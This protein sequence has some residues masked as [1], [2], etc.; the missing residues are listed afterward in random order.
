VL[1]QSERPDPRG[2][3]RRGQGPQEQEGEGSRGQRAVTTISPRSS[4]SHAS[5]PIN[6]P[7]RISKGINTIQS[8]GK[9]EHEELLSNRLWHNTNTS[10]SE[11]MAVP[12]PVA[13]LAAVAAAAAAQTDS[14][15]RT[16][17]PDP[18]ER[19]AGCSRGRRF[20][21]EYLQRGRG[22]M[23]AISAS[24]LDRCKLSVRD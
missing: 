5:K 21:P 20:P 6:S 22:N 1:R 16:H 24:V 15:S 11:R 19:P 9:Q 12:H 23:K 8:W 4:L 7:S 10:R 3:G 17:L 13:A 2:K 18:A 14:C